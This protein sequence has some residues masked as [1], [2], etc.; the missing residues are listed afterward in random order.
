M[1]SRLLPLCLAIGA[2]LA[3]ATGVHHI[4]FYLVLLAVVGAA[5]GAAAGGGLAGCCAAAPN[6]NT[7]I[8]AP[9]SNKPRGADEPIIMTNL[10]CAEALSARGRTMPAPVAFLG[11]VS[12][13]F[14]SVRNRKHVLG[15][16]GVEP[17]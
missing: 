9:A 16:L 4:A 6:V 12:N 11:T 1:G 13:I 8:K 3:D 2:L 5:A 7:Q 14:P 17:E 10:S 15:R